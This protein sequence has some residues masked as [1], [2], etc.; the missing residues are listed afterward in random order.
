MRARR[1]QLGLIAL[2]LTGVAA[3]SAGPAPRTD[4]APNDVA[5]TKPASAPSLPAA[6]R[7]ES[8]LDASLERTAERLLRGAK[9]V[10]GAIVALDPKTGNVLAFRA[11]ASGGT[12]FD[13]LTQARLPAASLFKVVTTTA[14][15][16]STPISLQDRVCINGGV[17]GIERRHLE[18]ARGPGTECGRFAWA[19]G[20]SKN[21]VF[22]QL[23]TRMLVRDDLL[24]TAERLGFNDKLPLDGG[25]QEAELGKLTV[26]YNDLD[27]ARAAAGFQG[28]S[29][30]P[31]GGAYL[32][33]L[34]ARGGAPVGLRL[35]EGS[36]E[37]NV[38]SSSPAFSARTARLLTRMLEVTVETGTSRGAFTAPDGKRYLPNIRVAGK[39]GTL[40]PG[41]G[42]DTM[43]SWFVGFAPSR[44]PEIV[45]SVMLVNGHTY[46]R[47]ANELARD[48]LR[49]YFHAH[50]HAQTVTDPFEAPGSD[51]LAARV[52]E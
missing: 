20:H 10:E 42:E 5:I 24:K 50:G 23:A 3:A 16:E 4:A 26:P 32:M 29:L 15:F 36:E 31:L 18:P 49:A 21:A 45:V 37:P 48:L 19:L 40:R 7:A 41:Q 46:R 28:S 27:F 33:T 13:V 47:K 35:H 30:S 44:N 17:H 34:I 8:T 14:L 2:I 51:A 22:A 11:I 9:P 6:S 39:T 25:A 38:T 43:T 1:Q 12:S 52:S